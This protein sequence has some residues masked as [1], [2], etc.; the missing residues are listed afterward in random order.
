MQNCYANADDDD[1][2]S[3]PVLSS[4][5]EIDNNNKLQHHHDDYVDAFPKSRDD[6]HDKVSKCTI[7]PR[8]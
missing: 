6:D 8:F 5:Q 2:V 7:S 1:A 3:N 4:P